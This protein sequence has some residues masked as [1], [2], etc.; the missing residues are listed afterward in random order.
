MTM[1]AF[2]SMDIKHTKGRWKLFFSWKLFNYQASPVII[3]VTA[4][5]EAEAEASLTVTQFNQIHYFPERQ[6][7]HFR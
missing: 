7:R 6:Q 5:D 2:A 4:S 3:T 1:R